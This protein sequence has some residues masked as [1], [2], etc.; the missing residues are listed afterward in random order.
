MTG[1]EGTTEPHPGTSIGSERRPPCR[2]GTIVRHATRSAVRRWSRPA[3]VD[4]LEKR[5]L[6]AAAPAPQPYEAELATVTGATVARSHAGYTGTGYVDYRHATGDA[7]QWSV[8][9]AA[10][11]EHVLT[12]RYANGGAS[13]RTMDLTLGGAFAKQVT[14]T[15]TGSWDAWQSVTVR[16][17][18]VAGANRVGLGAAGTSG[19]N[20]DWLS[21]RPAVDTYQAEDA[22]LVGAAVARA[23]AGFTG[24]GYVDYQHAA[25]DSVE[26]TVFADAAGPYSLDLRYANKG[27]DRPLVVAV[28]G[29]AQPAVHFAPTGSWDRWATV[30]VPVTLAV[31]PNRVRLTAAG[32]SGPNVD[33]M[34]VRA[35]PPGPRPGINL[36]D[37][38]L[39]IV[40]GDGPDSMA[41]DR[42]DADGADN[43]IAS[44]NGTTR[45]FPAA[46]VARIELYG[47]GGND[48]SSGPGDGR[49][50]ILVDG[51]AG[52]DTLDGGD[53]NDTL[54]GGEGDDVLSGR[55]GDDVIDG[56]A[57]ADSLDGWFGNDTVDY[58]SHT[59]P[60]T[61]RLGTGEFFESGFFFTDGTGGV[62][63]QPP[64]RL[65]NFE[66]AT[67][68]AGNDLLVGDYRFNVLS[69]GGGDDP[70]LGAAGGD[71]LNGG[72]GRDLLDGG[73]DTDAYT[74]DGATVVD[75]DF[76]VALGAD[77]VLRAIGTDADDVLS[78]TQSGATLTFAD[79]RGRSAA[80]PAASVALIWL[81]GSKGNDTLRLGNADGSAAPAIPAHLGGGDGNDT[82]I[83]GA[84]N[85]ELWGGF[86]DDVLD[87][88]LGDDTVWGGGH[89]DTVDYSRRSAPVTVDLAGRID[90]FNSDRVSSLP[91][92]GTGGQAGE[93]DRIRWD[94]FTAVGGSGNDTLL[95]D[96]STTLRGGAGDDRLQMGF[97][98][99]SVHI[100]GIVLDGG[101]GNDNLVAQENATGMMLGGEG[102]D[103][104]AP[105]EYGGAT[106][107]G[108]PGNDTVRGSGF[109]EYGLTFDARGTN[110]E[111]IL[112][113]DQDDDLTGTDAA[114]TIDGGNGND[115][116]N[117]LGGDDVL[118]GG[119]GADTINAGAG[120]D[121]IFARSPF[122]GD[123][124]VLDGGPGTDSAQVGDDDQR[125]SIEVLL[126]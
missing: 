124:D 115:R 71:T 12:F 76:T 98:D 46:S 6:L 81:D 11:G 119:E 2:E 25:G 1:R 110:V 113:S 118:T 84:K 48:T 57:G 93:A 40:G 38:V 88:G 75:R 125:Q 18:L 97:I 3:G 102:D 47:N 53:G 32:S 79:N 95:G 72:G 50:N 19:P 41:V 78:V 87:G 23:H 21:V 30:T 16:L 99:D 82:L 60:V 42:N 52:N 101:P 96:D 90:E 20:V 49:V 28:N 4:V 8:S 64:E 36:R 92:F 106:I 105:H 13:T 33:A 39:T 51:G 24:T 26:W 107:D 7:V 104:L 65:F 69:G 35:G 117:G 116:V 85:D 10:A 74:G 59:R 29:A 14:F 67:G 68:G 109:F 5:T 34:T 17:P 122:S 73:D 91:L 123:A 61:V 126:A 44:L 121:T 63:G 66:N 112:G 9:A 55:S 89:S 80:F 56:G 22:A 108:G 103:S 43:I 86:G 111:I 70:L 54:R 83:G 15:P 62:T 114:D 120:N 100:S 58:S 94:V 37:G 45:T 31:G 77:H 27:A